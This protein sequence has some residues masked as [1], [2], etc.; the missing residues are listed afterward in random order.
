MFCEKSYK[1]RRSRNRTSSFTFTL[2]VIVH[3]YMTHKNVIFVPSKRQ[4]KTQNQRSNTAGFAFL[5]QKRRTSTTTK[6]RK[7][8][9]GI[10]GSSYLHRRFPGLHIDGSFRLD[11]LEIL[12]TQSFYQKSWRTRLSP[13]SS[14]IPLAMEARRGDG[15]RWR[16]LPR[17]YVLTMDE[18]AQ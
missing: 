15:R 2:T 12:S 7:K 16:K 13:F 1:R 18:K 9:D 5:T 6:L 4:H 17:S 10:L 11:L 8:N 14:G 3:L